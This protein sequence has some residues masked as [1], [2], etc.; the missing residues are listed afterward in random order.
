MG[1]AGIY[2]DNHATTRCDPRVVTA[3]LPYFTDHYGNASSRMHGFGQVAADAVEAARRRVAAAIG[4][5][6]GEIVFTSGATESNRLAVDAATSRGRPRALTSAVEHKTL[7]DLSCPR[8]AIPVLGDGILDVA[9]LRAAIG[10]D[11]GCVAVMAA[12][13]EIGTVQ[14]VA[15]VAAACRG[16]GVAFV[17]DATAAIGR[18]PIDVRAIDADFLSFSAHKIYGPKGVGALFVRARRGW[19]VSRP[20]TANVPGVVGLAAALDLCMEELSSES[21]RLLGLRTRLLDRLSRAITGVRVNGD[22][23]RRLPGNL[24][25]TVDGIDGPSLIPSLRG[26]AVSSGSACSTGAAEPS[27]VLLAI[28]RSR[29]EALAAV[30]FGIGR[31]NT[32]ADVDGAVAIVAAAVG[33]LRAG[34]RAGRQT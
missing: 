2:L 33:K 17:T 21:E 22:L 9:A 16:A 29:T 4:A 27:H 1:A 23:D 11:V 12:N 5:E 24:N 7:V 26:L 28:G 31:F 19:S 14:P 25:V 10:P 6:P 15:D 18:V 30:R 34:A 8:T 3:M 20:G 13:S 32:E